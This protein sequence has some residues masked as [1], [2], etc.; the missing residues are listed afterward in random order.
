MKNKEIYLV[1]GDEIIPL[2]ETEYNCTYNV[3]LKGKKELM[4]LKSKYTAK[5]DGIRY[6]L[7]LS[8]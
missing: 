4:Y 5:I 1:K 8:Y 2:F 7:E 6:N 3:D